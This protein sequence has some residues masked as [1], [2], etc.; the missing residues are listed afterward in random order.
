M[1]SILLMPLSETF[2]K[3]F[4]ISE[5]NDLLV[6][7]LTS[8]V[9]KFLLFTP[10]MSKLGMIDLCNS[11]SLWTS[12]STS[13]CKLFANSENCFISFLVRM[14]AINKI[15]SAPYAFASKSW[16][17]SMIN[18]LRNNG[19]LQLALAVNKS[20]KEPPKYLPSVNTDIPQTPASS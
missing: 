5:L 16:Y 17:S 1:V 8:N 12:K 6:S 3:S 4:G 9:F 14:A 10:N 19:K 7:K 13:K 20:S 11:S 2:T 15:T 18:S